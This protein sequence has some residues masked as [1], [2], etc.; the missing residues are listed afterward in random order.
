MLKYLSME[1]TGTEEVI[2]ISPSQIKARLEEERAKGLSKGTF[3]YH[4]WEEHVVPAYEDAGQLGILADLSAKD[5]GLLQIAALYHDIALPVGREGHEE[6]SARIAEEDLKS[7]G[8][9]DE[10]IAGVKEIILGTMGK[11]E[12][13][14][15]VTEPS[16]NP[17]VNL[18]RDIDLSNVGKVNYSELGENLRIEV[19][20]EDKNAW[21]KFQIEFLSKHRFHRKEAEELWEEQKKIN[22]QNLQAKIIQVGESFP[23]KFEKT[24]QT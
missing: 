12:D 16:D 22:L 10:D 4:N 8:Y 3:P 1:D 2:V 20:V 21:R 14:V 5:I 6:A 11:M 24:Y 17:L 15:Y 9:T 13:G 7:F 18:M 23:K 19:G